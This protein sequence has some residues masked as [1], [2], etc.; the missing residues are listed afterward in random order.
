[1]RIL[2]LASALCLAVLSSAYAQA[3]SPIEVSHAWARATAASAANGAVYL[4]VMNHGTADDR[5]TGASTTVAAK[6]E[7]HITLNDNG[8][9]KMRPMA[10]VPVKAGGSAEFK[11]DGMHI[12]LL[13]LKHPLKA[14]EHFPLTLT[15]EKAGAVKTMVIVQK[16][17]AAAPGSMP[18]M[19][20]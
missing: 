7:L 14:G 13:G 5:L 4:K 16:A 8:V 9:M 1:M 19:K 18:G 20:M 12:M 2:A 6:A 10:D 3:S 11:P 17:G 15:F